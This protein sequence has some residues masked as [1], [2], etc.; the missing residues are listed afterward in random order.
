M[1]KN[2]ANHKLIYFILI[3]FLSYSTLFSF[4][5][6]PINVLREPQEVKNIRP[7]SG[8]EEKEEISYPSGSNA[9]SGPST[10]GQKGSMS[11]G[12]GFA[13]VSIKNS[14]FKSYMIP[15]S[16]SYGLNET[17]DLSISLP[18]AYNK[19]PAAEN[20]KGLADIS[21]SINNQFLNQDD[22]GFGLGFGA[23]LTFPT[24][25]KDIVGDNNKTD[26]NLTIKLEK[27]IKSNSFNF[28]F[29]YNY[30]DC[31]KF[32]SSDDSKFS[33]G[34]AYSRGFSDKFSASLELTT[35]DIAANDNEF[36]QIL[37][38]GSRYAI[39]NKLSSTLL[40]GRNIGDSALNNLI[41]TSLSYS[42]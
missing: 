9:V 31:G 3:L 32:T 38:L 7:L 6:T 42:F 5:Q 30:N 21:L 33:Y 23:S 36:S 20:Q 4:T 13:Y 41:I 15:F 40:L 2:Y 34:I 17:N 22:F 27:K 8:I 24:G 16:F 29:G 28:S 26:I 14:D 12:F 37:F 25:D 10:S 19:I 35:P 11:A 1:R 18:F 39:S